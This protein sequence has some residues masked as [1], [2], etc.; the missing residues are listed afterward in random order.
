MTEQPAKKWYL[1]VLVVAS[2]VDDGCQTSPLIDLQ[3]KL[4]QAADAEGAYRRALELGAAEA[5]SYKNADGAEVSWEFLGLNELCELLETDLY[6]G[7]EV[8]SSL[9]R[10]APEQ[11]LCPKEKLTVFWI[12]ANQH[13]TAEELLAEYEA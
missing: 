5:H 9:R 10:G 3:Y 7:V 2:S 1:A 11:L 4:L 12:D 13:K 6:D 8:F